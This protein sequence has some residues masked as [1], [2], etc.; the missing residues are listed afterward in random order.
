MLLLLP[1]LLGQEHGLDV[2]QN[3]TLRDGNAL[4]KLVQLLVIANGELQMARVDARL[5]VV[6]SSVASQLEDLSRKV[7]H[8]GREVHWSTGAN[9]LG[10]VALSEMTMDPSD[11]ELESRSGASALCLSLR[12]AAFATSRHV[13]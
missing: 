7:F 9:S 10:V 3:T 4:Q 8:D 6:T 12:F 5:L 13:V 11:R 2:R 1:S